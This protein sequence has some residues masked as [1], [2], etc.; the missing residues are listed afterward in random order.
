M[1]GVDHLAGMGGSLKWYW[2]SLGILFVSLLSLAGGQQCSLDHQKEAFS[3]QA[4]YRLLPR[5]FR[6]ACEMYIQC[7][8]IAKMIPRRLLLTTLHSSCQPRETVVTLDIPLGAMQVLVLVYLEDDVL[9]YEASF[10]QMI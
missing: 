1:I 4:Q 8:N 10:Y 6:R 5:S 7:L 2:D 9:T 3:L